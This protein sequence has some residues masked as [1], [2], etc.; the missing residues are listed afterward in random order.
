MHGVTVAI[1]GA[2]GIGYGL[3]LVKNLSRVGVDTHLLISA[4]GRAV[5]ATE[6][7]AHLPAEPQQ[8]HT[9][10]TT[11]LAIE[12]HRLHVHGLEDWFSGLA[13]GSS[14]P[15]RMVVCPCSMGT[16]AALAGSHSNNLIERAADVVL[17]ERGNLIVVPREAPLSSTHL[18]HMLSLSR[19]GAVILPACPAFYH[20]PREIEELL[21]YVVAR[22]LDHLQ[23]EHSL[24]KRW[25]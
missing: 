16:L 10:L 15:R 5:A 13:S 24:I 11:E 21:D 4:A 23:I 20:Q 12:A 18:E 19:L 1:T 6:Q 9:Q 3:R 7:G 8:I 2:S 17:K 14:A 25:G 22:I